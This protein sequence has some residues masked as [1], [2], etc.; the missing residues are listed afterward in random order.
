MIAVTPWLET[1]MDATATSSPHPGP[2]RTVGSPVSG[3]GAA[4]DRIGW[5]RAH[6]LLALVLAGMFFDALEQDTTG[7]IGWA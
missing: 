6:W 7:A 1:T 4:M 5:T 3:L 2:Q